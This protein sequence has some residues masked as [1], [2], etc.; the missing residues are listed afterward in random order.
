M[1][2]TVN[3]QGNVALFTNGHAVTTTFTDTTDT[4]FA[5][6]SA[7]VNGNQNMTIVGAGTSGADLQETSLTWVSN[8]TVTLGTSAPTTVTGAN[9]TWG[10][11]VGETNGAT[12]TQL[13]ATYTGAIAQRDTIILLTNFDPSKS[14]SSITDTAGNTYTLVG[15]YAGTEYNQ[16]LYIVKRAV[17]SSAGSNTV[18]I[19]YSGSVVGFA[20][21]S[22]YT[23]SGLDNTNPVDQYVTDTSTGTTMTSGSITTKYANEAM[24]AFTGIASA[25]T[26]GTA[27]WTTTGQDTFGDASEYKIVSAIQTGVTATFT[28]SPS[29]TADITV[30]TLK[31]GFSN[32]I[33][34]SAD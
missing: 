8:T 6:T 19:T 1:A 25:V 33:F 31:Q 30:V 4:P 16:G 18:Q 11:V 17:A 29:S 32:S 14:V 26:G 23:L 13:K 28:T 5:G 34:F 15:T 27:G 22:F 20:S 12:G 3:Q 24:F 7:R 2:I 9:W 21:I 10:N